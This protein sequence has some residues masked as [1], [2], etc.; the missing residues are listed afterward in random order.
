MHLSLIFV[1]IKS[2]IIVS[3]IYSAIHCGAII[4]QNYQCNRYED[5]SEMSDADN[6][7]YYAGLLNEQLPETVRGHNSVNIVLIIQVILFSLAGVLF[8]GLGVW[9]FARWN[10]RRNE[11]SC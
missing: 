11:S 7:D 9:I 6:I 2:L 4:S 5:D 3:S 1:I 10:R 8:V